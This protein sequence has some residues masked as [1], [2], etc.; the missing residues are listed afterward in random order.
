MSIQYDMETILC[1]YNPEDDLQVNEDG[2]PV[3]SW[4]ERD[5]A[6]SILKLMQYNADLKQIIELIEQTTRIEIN[7]LRTQVNLLEQRIKKLEDK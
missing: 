1:R 7:I 4:A 2:E 3:V 5:L 6:D